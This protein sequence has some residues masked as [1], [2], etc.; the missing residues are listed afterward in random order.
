[1]KKHSLILAIAAAG[2]GFSAAASAQT[3]TYVQGDIGLANLQV[4]NSDVFHSREL[5]R[6]IKNAYKDSGFMPRLSIGVDTGALRFAA[7]YTHYKKLSDSASEGTVS[8]NASVKASGFGVSA[9][10]DFENPDSA[11]EPY[12]G[13]RLAI[14]KIKSEAGFNVAGLRS[15]A[16]ES[17]TK[18]G[19]GL[20]GGVNYKLSN[21]MLLD[22]GYRY[23][24]MTSDV[25]AHEFSAGLRYFF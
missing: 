7:D 1:M 8:L 15:S 19:F 6:S 10:Y 23:N 5:G 9:F 14:N 11:F 24:R 21:D 25:Y 2:L 4:D 18:L 16:S 13:G 20:M 12:L 22:F 17:E 3:G